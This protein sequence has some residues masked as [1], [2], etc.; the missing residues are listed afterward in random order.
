MDRNGLRPIRYTITKDNKIVLASEAGV[1]EID[2]ENIKEKG[3]L[4]SGKILSIDFEQ[5]KV[6]YDQEIKES[7]SKSKPYSKW[8]KKT[9]LP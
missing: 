5:N 3:N 1:I 7:I 4:R 9:G 2:P 6:V 8:L